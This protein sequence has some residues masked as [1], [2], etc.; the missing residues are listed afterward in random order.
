MCLPHLSPIG[1]K[2][3]RHSWFDKWYQS[4]GHGFES[5]ECHCEGGIVGGH[6]LTSYNHSKNKSARHYVE[7]YKKFKCVFFITNYFWGEMTQLMVQQMISEPGS[8]VQVAR[9]LLCGRDCY[10]DHNLTLY[11]HSKSRFVECNIECH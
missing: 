7:W 6:N 3:E 4:Q 2:V 5:W 8:W 1:F 9:V 11:N 10:G